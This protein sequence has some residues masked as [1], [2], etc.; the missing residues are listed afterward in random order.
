[1]FCMLVF[2]EADDVTMQA[3]LARGH[4]ATT[5]AMQAGRA[6]Q[7][8]DPPEPPAAPGAPAV[9]G[10]PPV[11]PDIPP[12][13]AMPPVPVVPATAPLIPPVGTTPPPAP[14]VPFDELLLLQAMA[15]SV[16]A[17]PIDAIRARGR[18][19]TFLSCLEWDC[20][21]SAI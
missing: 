10:A 2:P 16:S 7:L 1:M 17:Q 5:E 15:P 6:P 11:V 13:P 9:P 14:P 8:T 3:L 18:V 21:T 20:E 19:M 12:A 4:A